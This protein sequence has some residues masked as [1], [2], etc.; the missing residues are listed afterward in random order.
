VKPLLKIYKTTEKQRAA[1]RAWNLANPERCR[2]I[3][4]NWREGRS[5]RRT[6]KPSEWTSTDWTR[7]KQFGITPEQVKE[8]V[9][10]QGG[11]AVCKTEQP[12]GKNQ[13][14]VDHDHASG[15]V[16]GIL[17]ITCNIALGMLHDDPNRARAA[18]VYLE[19]AKL[20]ELM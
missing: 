9:R 2:E 20:K 3:Q 7:F 12:R 14:H 10:T 6:K 4:R 8:Q 5:T 15:L 18:A 1:A 19:A 16:R 17:C 13:W 11:C